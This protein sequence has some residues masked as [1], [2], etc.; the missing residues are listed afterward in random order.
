[1]LP[2]TALVARTGVTARSIRHWIAVGLVP[3]PTGRNAGARY[4]ETHVLHVNAVRALRESERLTMG[5]LKRRMR[6]ASEKDLRALL[7]E[8]KTT[9]PKDVPPPPPPPEYPHQTQ[10]AITIAPGLTLVIAADAP[11][12]V[13]RMAEAIYRHYGAPPAQLSPLASL[14]TGTP[15]ST[16]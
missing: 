7:P 11:L 1:M 10:R 14:S 12:V 6:R 16:G 5:E 13:H 2:M 9:A 15:P 8:A 3:H 4:G